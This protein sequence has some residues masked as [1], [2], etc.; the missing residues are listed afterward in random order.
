MDIYSATGAIVRNLAIPNRNV[1]N[2]PIVRLSG[3]TNW[4]IRDFN[5]HYINGEFYEFSPR[6]GELSRERTSP[7]LVDSEWFFR[8]GPG[9]HVTPENF[10]LVQKILFATVL[11]EGTYARTN[12]TT[13]TAAAVTLTYDADGHA[14]TR[15]ETTE[16]DDSNTCKNVALETVWTQITCG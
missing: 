5:N 15:T 3:G 1:L 14:V 12:S 2:D 16:T 8:T 4:S 7:I 10:E 11:P 9:Q 6:R 13:G